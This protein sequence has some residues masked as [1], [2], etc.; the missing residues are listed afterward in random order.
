MNSHRGVLSVWNVAY[1]GSAAG[2][3]CY[4]AQCIIRRYIETRKAAH[5]SLRQ[6]LA[7]CV[8]LPTSYTYPER[9][10]DRLPI[11]MFA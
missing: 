10:N 3:P 9:D 1:P 11:L 2:L 4:M 7:P 5:L 6:V 8:L